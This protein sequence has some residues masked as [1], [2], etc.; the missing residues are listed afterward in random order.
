MAK[1]LITAQLVHASV[2][3]TGTSQK[4]REWTRHSILLAPADVDINGNVEVFEADTFADSLPEIGQTVRVVIEDRK[5]VVGQ[6]VYTD[7]LATRFIP[8]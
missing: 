4:G 8:V 3:A 2:E 6:Q 7:K 5:R 1:T